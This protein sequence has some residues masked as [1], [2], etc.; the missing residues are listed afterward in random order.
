M[1]EMSAIL[2]TY[3]YCKRITPQEFDEQRIS[4]SQAA[5]AEL[6]ENIIRD[7]TL[8]LKDKKKKLKQVRRKNNYIFF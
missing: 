7:K 2:P 6:L 4:A 1:E 8:S 5:V 3:S